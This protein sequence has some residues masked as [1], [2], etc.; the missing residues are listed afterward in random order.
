MGCDIYS[1]CQVYDNGDWQTVTDPIFPYYENRL[2][3]E[4]FSTRHY[5]LFGFLANVRNYSAVPFLSE[6]KGLPQDFEIEWY[7]DR[8]SHSWFTL[9]ELLD[10]DYDREFED[11]RVTRQVSPN[12]FNG[13]ITGEIGEGTVTTFRDFLGPNYFKTLDIM[14]S[15]GAPENVRVIFCF[16]S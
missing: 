15:L 11:R 16:D 12:F 2:T 9:R 1:I 10:F 6:P 7:F 13:G 8:H 5:G 14:Q 3:A 4:P